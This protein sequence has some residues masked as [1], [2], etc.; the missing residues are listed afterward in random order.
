MP[1]ELFKF[2]VLGPRVRRGRDA[3][4]GKGH[5]QVGPEREESWFFGLCVLVPPGGGDLGPGASLGLSRPEGGGS[6]LPGGQP[7]GT[8]VSGPS[9]DALDVTVRRWSPEHVS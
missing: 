9:G 7:S 1:R 8:V 3:P 6:A 2:L 4:S 5:S